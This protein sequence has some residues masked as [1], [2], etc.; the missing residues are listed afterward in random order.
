MAGGT[1]SSTSASSDEAPTTR[2]MSVMSASRGPMW[3]RSNA[4]NLSSLMS[5]WSALV[6]RTEVRP[7]LISAPYASAFSSASASPGFASLIATIHVSCGAEFTISGLSLSAGLTS[8]TSPDTGAN[9][10]DTA[11]TDSIVP[12]DCPCAAVQ[13]DPLVV[14]RVLERVGIHALLPRPLVE[15]QWDDAGFGAAA[16]NI[17][18]D[19]AA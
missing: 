16:A 4:S 12:N 18:F 3:R 13:A 6:G 15:R 5:R 2:S 1:T 10:S 11:F 8:T 14:L 17:D 19:V 9:S 7:Y